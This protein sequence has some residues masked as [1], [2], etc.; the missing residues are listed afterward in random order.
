MQS[1]P[2]IYNKKHNSNNNNNNNCLIWSK[3]KV[4]GYRF[5]QSIKIEILY[6]TSCYNTH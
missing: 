2:R 3:Q 1:K 6:K 4:I 5:R